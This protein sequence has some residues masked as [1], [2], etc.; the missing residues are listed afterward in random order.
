MSNIATETKQM[1][2]D[3]DVDGFN[4]F[5]NTADD[6]SNLFNS[7]IIKLQNVN[8]INDIIFLQSILNVL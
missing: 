5:A 1:Q 3:I 2:L 6:L 4:E 7:F 8:I